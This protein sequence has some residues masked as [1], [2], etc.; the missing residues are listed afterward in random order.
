[1]KNLVL[2]KLQALS[3]AH[4]LP[5]AWLFVG[6]DHPQKLQTARAFSQWQLCLNKQDLLSC[7]SCK[8]CKLFLA[9]THPD[10][11]L[12]TTQ[13]DKTTILVDEVRSAVDFVAAKAQL[14]GYKIVLLDPAEVM[15]HGA[16]NALLKSLEEPHNNTVFLLLCK[17]Q[18]LLL[19]TI[20][21][22]C[23]ILNFSASTEVDLAIMQ[24][25]LQDLAAVFIEKK[26]TVSQIVEP[27]LKNWP[28]EILNYLE[29]VLMD[30][31]R[32]KYTQDLALL[33]VNSNI[34][35]ELSAQIATEKIWDVIQRLQQAKYWL[36]N[37][38]RLNQQLILEDLLLTV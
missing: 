17:H 20:V 10:F 14:N 22:R 1:M 29:L 33:T 12:L 3:L 26:I 16:A 19:K 9:N 8:S 5:H 36:G 24:Q 13:A 7:G 15:P 32:F 25:I 35:L 31:I 34:Y 38:Y 28:Q 30:L 37:N 11:L 2:A 6:A 23:Q 27:W 18:R 4:K 21:S